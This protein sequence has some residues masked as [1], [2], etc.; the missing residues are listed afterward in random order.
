MENQAI[1]E[2][3]FFKGGKTKCKTKFHRKQLMSLKIMRSNKRYKIAELCWNF[4][5]PRPH[6]Q[7]F[8][9]VWMMIFNTYT[10][11]NKYYWMFQYRNR[12]FRRYL[13][14]PVIVTD[15]IIK[16]LPEFRVLLKVLVCCHCADLFLHLLQFSNLLLYPLRFLQRCLLCFLKLN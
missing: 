10:G 4:N 12:E 9:E 15:L 1:E 8:T 7:E 2:I 14:S 3:L 5:K 16:L 6:V 11:A 13:V